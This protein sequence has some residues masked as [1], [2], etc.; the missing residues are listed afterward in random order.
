MFPA[1]QDA[2]E[3]LLTW[4]RTH[5][6]IAEHV[7]G[8]PDPLEMAVEIMGADIAVRDTFRHNGARRARWSTT[9]AT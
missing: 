3:Q 6:L 5:G 2:D 4:M 1:R 7:L 9:A 8:D